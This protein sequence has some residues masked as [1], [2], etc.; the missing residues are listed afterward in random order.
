MLEAGAPAGEH[1]LPL[2]Q[3]K[4]CAKLSHLV[5]L[6]MQRMRQLALA[7]RHT[8][9]LRSHEDGTNLYTTCVEL[10]AYH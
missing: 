4:N 7:A 10:A 1:G 2:D 3:L 5:R 8:N 6:S 9:A